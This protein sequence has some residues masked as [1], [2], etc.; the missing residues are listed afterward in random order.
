MSV[1]FMSMKNTVAKTNRCSIPSASSPSRFWFCLGILLVISSLLSLPAKAAKAAEQAEDWPPL[2]LEQI[3]L[4]AGFSI[5]VYARLA[6]PRALTLS[7]NGTVYVGSRGAGQVYALRDEDED[8]VAD[9]LSLLASGLNSPSGVAWHDGDLYVGTIPAILRLPNIDEQLNSPPQAEV[10]YSGFSSSRHH[11]SRYIAIGPDER[12]YAAVGAPCNVCL[13]PGF[14]SIV[15]MNLDGSGYQTV[16]EGVRNSVGFDFHPK[17]AELWFTDNGRDRLGDDQ[18]ACELNRLS[19]VGEHFG[20][21]YCHA[22]DLLDPK[23]G[24]GQRCADYTPP[25]QKLGPHVAPLGMRFIRSEQ[26]PVAYRNKPVIAEHGSWNR[27]KKIGYRLTL[28]GPQAEGA[29]RYTVFASGWLQG[30]SAWGRPADVLNLPDGSLL[31]SDDY[32]DAIY[33]ISYRA[34]ADAER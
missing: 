21:P 33:R 25:V 32:A 14:A 4:P 27:S 2:F 28:V 26:F 3:K 12:L 10:V 24:K 19:Q 29:A 11:G 18:P 17:T 8:G 5:A 6:N 13:E 15:R 7:D 31:V 23:F 30:E 16:A 34:E 9:Q 20:F 22:G 1:K